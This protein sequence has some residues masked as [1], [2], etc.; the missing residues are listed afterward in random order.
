MK[1]EVSKIEPAVLEHGDA[2]VDFQPLSQLD[3]SA[4]GFP[5]ITDRKN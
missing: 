2:K 5:C 3:D 1:I 4:S